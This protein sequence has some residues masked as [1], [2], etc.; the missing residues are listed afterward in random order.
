MHYV[1]QVDWSFI[2]QPA[3]AVRHVVGSRRLRHRRPGPGR[4]PHRAR[5]RRARC[6][7]AGSRR[8]V[9]SFEEALYVLAGELLLDIDGHV[10]RL[11]AG[12]FALSRSGS[13]TRSAT[14]RDEPVR[15]F[16]VNTP[17]AARPGARPR[18]DTFFE[19]ARSTSRRWRSGPSG[20]RSAI[21]TLRS[22][23]H[24]DGTPPQAEAL[25]VDGPGPRSRAGR[26]GHRDPGLQRDLGEDAGRPDLRAPTC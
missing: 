11:A 24:Y 21:P 16:S 2:D 1:G 5:R 6:R 8:H 14:P 15:W 20:R 19:P 26:D 7:A 12:D 9:H 3:P 23:G 18:R 17:A 10:H 4:G 22:V 25:R 13:G